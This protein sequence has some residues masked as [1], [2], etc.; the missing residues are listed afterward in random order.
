MKKNYEEELKTL[1]DNL[2]KCLTDNGN[3]GYFVGNKVTKQTD[4]AEISFK[5]QVVPVNKQQT[6]FFDSCQYCFCY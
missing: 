5:L 1:F 6:N 4:W 2:E 3:T